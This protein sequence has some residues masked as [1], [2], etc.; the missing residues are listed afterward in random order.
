MVNPEG[1]EGRI[2]ARRQ[3]NRI[4]E[5]YGRQNQRKQRCPMSPG[6]VYLM[7]A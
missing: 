1:P 5:S 6:Y 2:G 7:S 3:T 4:C